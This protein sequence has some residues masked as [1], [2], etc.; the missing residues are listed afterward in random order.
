MTPDLSHPVVFITTVQP[1]LVLWVSG[2]CFFVTLAAVAILSRGRHWYEL[3]CLFLLF[4]LLTT[5]VGLWGTSKVMDLKL[6]DLEI[7]QYR[8]QQ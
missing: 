8:I 2:V 4:F 7:I 1:F 5:T 3:A 6:F